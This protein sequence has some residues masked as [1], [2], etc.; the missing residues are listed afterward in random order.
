M[1]HITIIRPSTLFLSKREN[2]TRNLPWRLID[3]DNNIT[4][5]MAGFRNNDPSGEFELYPGEGI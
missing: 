5:M 1:T 2:N 4:V 3:N